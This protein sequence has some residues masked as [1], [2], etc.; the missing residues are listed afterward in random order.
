MS[1]SSRAAAAR[2]SAAAPADRSLNLGDNVIAAIA[3]LIHDELAKRDVLFLADDDRQAEA[4]ARALE[5]LGPAG[6]VVHIPAS[7]A[8]PGEKAPASPA[9]IGQRVAALRLLRQAVAVK[10][11]RICC[12][13]S[14]EAAAQPYP[15]P[16]A[17]AAAPPVM[18]VGDTV[19]IAAFAATIEALGY[20]A[21]ERVDEPGEVAIRGNVI[22]LFPADAGAP[23]RIEL[24]DDRIVAIRAFDAVTQL[25]TG[26]LETIA[27]GRANEP[28][29]DPPTSL[30]DHL[31]SGLVIAA[32]KA[33]ARRR[34]Y[35]ALAENAAAAP[36]GTP[37]A[38]GDTHW[39]KALSRWKVV[40]DDAAGHAAIPRFA[41]ARSPLAALAR[42]AGP[43]IENRI[44]LLIGS[45]RD[46]RFLRPRIAKRLGISI[47]PASTL[48]EARARGAGGAA[49]LIVPADRGF[50]GA[51]L[52]VVAAGDLLGSRA[53]VDRDDARRAS[54]AIGEA[55]DL[56]VGDLVIHEDH[57]VARVEGL[58]PAPGTEGE[59]IVLGFSGGARRLVAAS[60]AGLLWRYGADAEA[61]ALDRLDG[62]SWQKRRASVSA[63]LDEIAAAL[64]K[65][66][67]ERERIEAPVLDPNAA[68][69]ERFVAG[70][71]FNETADQASAF[72]AVRDDLASGK[73]MDRLVIGDVGFGKTEVALRAAAIA[74]IAG[75]QVIVAAPTTV[76][77]RQHLAL[78]AKRFEPI[79]VTVAGL[80]RLSSAAEKKVVKQGLA[81]GTID[82]VVGTGAVMGKS[83]SYQRLGLVIIDEEQKFG[84]ADKA[85]L[86]Q[87][88]SVHQL[89]MSATPIPRTLQMAMTG[90]RQL[91]V[92]ATP[93]ARRQPVRTSLGQFDAPRIRTLLLREHA[94]R[95]QSFVV[96]PRIEDMAGVADRLRRAVPEL[97]IAEVHG[98]VPAKA[99]DA[100]M[101]DFAGGKG[102]ILLATNI[103][104][105]GLDIPRANTMIV[106]RADRFGLAQLHQLRGRVGRGARRGQMLLLTEE[107]AAIAEPTWKRL[108]T[109]AALDQL[110]AGFE[111]SASDLDAR[112]SGDLLGD[113]QSGHRALVGA[114]LYQHLLCQAL[115]RS[116][117]DA[118][119]DWGPQIHLGEEGMI[120]LAWVPE[121]DVR[122]PL[123]L[124]L[125]R[126]RSDPELV[127]FEAE[128][129][130]RF[131]PIPPEAERLLEQGRLRLLARA[132]RIAKID[133]GSA[134]I[135]LTPR[136]DFA[137]DLAALGCEQKEERWIL[138]GAF[139]DRAAAARQMLEALLA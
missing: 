65:L 4:L 38:I 63:A 19:E 108:R 50:I 32:P 33:D 120:P 51:D 28:P 49:S 58:E 34:R 40:A 6:T 7:D 10:E 85:R 119:E 59:M 137:G 3:C 43:L 79:G 86:R 24:S 116:R 17:F 56:R 128:L 18:R 11:M 13:A 29:R 71:A 110:G 93:P 67:A 69:F 126:L 102:D 87:N 81:D 97:E 22:D 133:A 74:A 41:E 77:V 96:V 9:N 64:T 130:D 68:R 27:I 111:V 15:P 82:I 114:D 23:V 84:A 112:G 139:T 54:P 117:G 132:A 121:I 62:S 135:A 70:F 98:K 122:L 1:V 44:V 46:L 20:Q 12:L 14:G 129:A 21:D 72:A 106:W 61:V 92:I 45:E 53:I 90:L 131:G 83:I 31:R 78:F 89:A 26:D 73:P 52:L 66:A 55:A 109:L 113:E 76:L 2:Q 136:G 105:A 25:M 30:L 127:A 47:E 94:R 99:A 115:A 48:A 134:A 103:I 60:D 8:L 125:A 16:K 42:F 107:N 36:D 101:V 118:D 88:L 138:K 100:I 57:G 91:S 124:R 39:Q 80:S 75:S 35:I 95:G 5:A 123:Y 104:E 37:E